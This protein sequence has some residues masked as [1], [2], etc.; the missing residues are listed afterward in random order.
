MGIESGNV[1]V[2]ID[3]GG[4]GCRVAI[5]YVDASPLGQA[6]GGPAFLL[7]TKIIRK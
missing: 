1:L 3:G 7:Y 6:T 2:G 4:T 5:T